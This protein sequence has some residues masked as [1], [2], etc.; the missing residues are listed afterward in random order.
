VDRV[1]KGEMKTGLIWHTQG[2]GKS[3]TMLFTA[4][5]LR[6]LEALNNPTILIVVD[7]I[8]LDEQISD[9]FTAVKM[10]NTSGASSISVYY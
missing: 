10:P 5:K 4:W 6:R 7:R 1:L 3:L 2:S 8:D 9:T